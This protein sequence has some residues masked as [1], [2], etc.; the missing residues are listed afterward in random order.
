MQ[1]SL[2]NSAL[3]FLIF[4]LE[5]YIRNFLPGLDW[6]ALSGTAFQTFPGKRLT[7]RTG[8]AVTPAC[9]PLRLKIRSRNI[10]ALPGFSDSPRADPEVNRLAPGLPV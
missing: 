4:Y 1:C 6:S 10:D 9:M 5:N 8:I 7:V 2:Q 3:L